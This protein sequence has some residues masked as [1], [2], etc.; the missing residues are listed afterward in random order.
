[1]GKYDMRPKTE[2]GVL[3]VNQALELI[4]D[5]V[6]ERSQRSD[7]AAISDRAFDL[8]LLVGRKSVKIVYLVQTHL[9]F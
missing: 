1:M 3:S 2:P 5:Q 8:E 9:L 6:A 4:F 7:S